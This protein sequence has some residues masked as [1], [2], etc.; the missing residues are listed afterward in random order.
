MSDIVKRLRADERYGDL[1]LYHEAADEIERQGMLSAQVHEAIAILEDGTPYERLHVAGILRAGLAGATP[2]PT[3]GSVV[4]NVTE[5]PIHPPGQCP[6]CLQAPCDGSGTC[7]TGPLVPEPVRQQEGEST[8]VD[9]AERMHRSWVEWIVP[10]IANR[11]R[12]CDRSVAFEALGCDCITYIRDMLTAAIRRGAHCVHFTLGPERE[13][14]A[15]ALIQDGINLTRWVHDTYP[16][17][18]SPA[19]HEWIAKA[20]AFI[21]RPRPGVPVERETGGDAHG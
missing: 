11:I 8:V 2:A 3:G 20:E 19:D 5:A 18:E 7:C 10:R 9:A 6:N 12:D 17:A 13:G 4:V 16:E 15:L 1:E 14:E 21:V